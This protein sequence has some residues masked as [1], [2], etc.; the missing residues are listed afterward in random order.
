[1]KIKFLNSKDKIIQ[2]DEKLDKSLKE[3][4]ELKNE[5]IKSKEHIATLQKNINS[6][7]LKLKEIE[8]NK[9]KKEYEYEKENRDLSISREKEGLLEIREKE[10]NIS[11]RKL[12]S[13]EYKLEEK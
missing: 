4:N 2:L 10:I 11:I 8:E 12:E 6:I 9:Q 5:N 1:M 7:S 13:D 3:K